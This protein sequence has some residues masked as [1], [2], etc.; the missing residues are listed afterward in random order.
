MSELGWVGEKKATFQKLTY[1]MVPSVYHSWNGEIVELRTDSWLPGIKDTDWC[2]YKRWTQEILQ[3]DGTVL[4]HDLQ[5]WVCKPTPMIKLYTVKCTH[6][7]SH[8]RKK[9]GEIWIR[10]VDCVSVDS[11]IVLWQDGRNI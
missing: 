3:V 1:C 9:L 5:W 4:Y 11:L 8:K 7:H 2:S 10:Q 6:E